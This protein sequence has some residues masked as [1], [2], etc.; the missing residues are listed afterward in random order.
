MV[1]MESLSGTME[2]DGTLNV[3]QMK[4]LIEEAKECRLPYTGHLI[5]VKIPLVTL[6]EA[7]E[8]GISTILTSG[9]KNT[10]IDGVELLK[11]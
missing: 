6:E 7:K 5:C 8:L 4:E 9:Q 2:P 1:Q 3:E 10:C 11:N